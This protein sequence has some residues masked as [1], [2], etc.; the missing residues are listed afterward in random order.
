MKPI[1]L[2]AGDPSGIGPEII[3]KAWR[4]RLTENLAPF[5]VVGDYEIFL[6]RE[7]I[8]SLNVPL[9][10]IKHP[11]DN[12]DFSKA[13]PIINIQNQ[14]ESSLGH[15]NKKNATG[16]IESIT[17]ATDFIFDNAGRAIVTAPISKKVLYDSGFGF[18]GHT[19]FLAH[20]AFQKTNKNYRPVMMLAEDELRTV[21]ITIHMALK[22]IF[23]HLDQNLI[24]ET[25]EI[26]YYAL[27]ENFLIKE[28][29]I[30]LAGLNPHA[31][32]DGAMGDEEEKILRPAIKQLK[33]KGINITGPY[34]ADTLFHKQ[35]RKKYDAALCLYHDQA[36]I[37]IKTIGFDSAV[38][39]TLGLPFIRTSPDHGTAFDI[40]TKNIASPE[41]LINAI[42]RADELTQ[43]LQYDR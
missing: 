6:Q 25:A 10:L 30:V 7:K 23:G 26:T 40:A 38:N 34:P 32:E 11:S 19:E 36:L 13:L 28:P 22:E 15:P 31:G 42:K 43:N 5:I 18:P 27:K 16:I 14:Q 24:I 8:F 4:A 9:Q 41:S 39:I 1:I 21:P 35:A 33:Q 12:F 20:I 29:H 17:K 37:P 3:L 2:S